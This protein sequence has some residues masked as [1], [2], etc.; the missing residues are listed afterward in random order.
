MEAKAIARYVRVSPQKAR[1]VVD[2]IRGKG[3]GEALDI[4]AFVRKAAA[5]P[6][7]KVLRSAVANAE[8]TRKVDVDKLYVKKIY[9]DHGPTMKRIHARAMGRA[10]VVRK[11][12]SHIT[13]VLDVR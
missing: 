3:V 11:R 13:V 8:N 5:K 4:L 12:M 7:V 6:V 10:A 2:L 9:V 1:L